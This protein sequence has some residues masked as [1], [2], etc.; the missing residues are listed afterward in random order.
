[1]GSL[2]A[3]ERAIELNP[4]N[5]TARINLR[6]AERCQRG[7]KE[8]LKAISIQNKFSELFAKHDNWREILK[9]NGPVDEAS[10]LFRTGRVLLV[11]IIV[12]QHLQTRELERGH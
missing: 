12:Y 10:F 5:L 8:R 7:D 9:A 4:E 6:Y 11:P 1:M 2:R 3:F